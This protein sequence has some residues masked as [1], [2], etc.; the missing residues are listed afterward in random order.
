MDNLTKHNQKKIRVLFCDQLNLARGKYL[1]ESIAS[2]GEAGIC[3]GVFAVT[4]S[5]QQINA[6][7]AGVDE[8]LPDVNL[9]YDPAQYRESWHENTKIAIADVYE[10]GKPYALCGRTALKNAIEA[11]RRHGLDPMVG[12]EGEAY[13]L[14][15]I[16]EGLKPYNTRIIRLWNGAI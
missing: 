9:C 11:W 12:L 13:V 2:S 14:E 16:S 5:R 1:P 4:Y 8:G 7:G 10:N 15:S 6:P 3:K